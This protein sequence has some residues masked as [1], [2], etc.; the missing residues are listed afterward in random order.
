MAQLPAIIPVSLLLS[1]FVAFLVGTFRRSLVYPITLLGIVTAL[2]A[3]VIGLIRVLQDGAQHYYF[4]GWPPP[5]GIEYVLDH[6]SGFMAVLVMF[7][8]LLSVI[9]S[10]RSFLQEVPEKI[11][12]LYSLISLMLAGLTGIILTGD[13]FNLYVFLEIA[14]L[15][16]YAVMAI[17]ND[18][19]PV[20][21][22]RYIIMGT[23]GAC[24][25]LLGVGFIY[26]ATG[27]LNMGDV[28][29]ILPSIYGSRLIVV[30]VTFI[31]IGMALK[32]ALF[33]LHIWLPDV[34]TYSPSAV[35]ALIAP[36]MT[37][38]GAYV[39]IRMLVSVFLPNYL[40]SVL[41]VTLIIGWLAAVGI[42]AMS[43]MAIAQKDFR[44]M[45]AYSSVAQICYVAL[46]I[47]LANSFGLI[48]ALLHVL[49]HAF[50]KCCLFQISGGVRYRTGL[51]QIP[52]FAGL[53]RHMRWTM[54]AFTVAAI[55]MVGIPPACGFFSKWYLV[56]GCID[57]GNWVFAVVVVASSLL[58]AVYFFR[59]LEKV[60]MV[61]PN[62]DS[63]VTTA[64]DPP[65][66][67]LAPM[68]IL[69]SGIIILGVVNA[70][71]V[72]QILEPVV[73]SAF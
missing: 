21:V 13:L 52:Q 27:S 19:A 66:E 47:G 69:A 29:R 6:L 23:I 16:A 40:T 5:L 49:N 73:F 8:A 62:N 28:A 55:S 50:M 59:V 46:G 42:V 51:W 63:I 17:G 33:P 61:S 70:V 53:G 18:K 2:V 72:A 14:S 37:K 1:A 3:A 30:A 44:R 58:N 71:I 12:P 38:V 7:I 4:G 10:R 35:I 64:S 45:L 48:G 54:G 15:A 57:A 22:I 26:F 25:Y 34:Y 43:V 9:Y 31:V 11:V 32:M 39:L 65:G 68:L 60:Y 20:A 36:I 41:P 56:L 67:M 24:F